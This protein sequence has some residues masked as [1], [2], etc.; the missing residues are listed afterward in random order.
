MI[1]VKDLKKSFGDLNVL[2]GVSVNIKK[3]EKVVVIGPSGSGKSTTGRT[4]IRLYDPTSGEV[5][6]DD[7]VSQE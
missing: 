4:I 7:N 6:F 2:N 1:E 3:G 5:I